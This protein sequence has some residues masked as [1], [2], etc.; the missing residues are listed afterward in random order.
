MYRNRLVILFCLLTFQALTAGKQNV[1][2]T[3]EGGTHQFKNQGSEALL[4]FSAAFQFKQQFH[5]HFLHFQARLIPEIIG[6]NSSASSL[7]FG[8]HLRTGHTYPKGGWEAGLRAKNYYYQLD[9]N[10][11]VYFAVADFGLSGFYRQQGSAFY[12]GRIN[13]IYRDLDTQPANHLDSFRSA[14]GLMFNFRSKIRLQVLFD[15]ERFRISAP[16]QKRIN[17]GWRAGPEINFHFRTKIFFHFSL[18]F[19][20]HS[21]KLSPKAGREIQTEIVFGK[22]IV[23]RL[24]LFAYLNYHLI[25]RPKTTIPEELL[26]STIENENWYYVKLEFEPVK[27]FA[28]YTK[29]GYF[30]DVL[31]ESRGTLS[32]LQIL[33]GVSWKT[34]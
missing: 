21:S 26:Y 27:R 10:N 2:L 6:L 19:L 12:F 23:P 34:L 16:Q 4:R 1:K 24:S 9:A 18:R 32:G 8:G 11:S 31:P 14:G 33:F 3:A 29:A 28:F 15:L 30:R 17:N 7:K 13:Y 5:Q 22:F 20:Y 25:K